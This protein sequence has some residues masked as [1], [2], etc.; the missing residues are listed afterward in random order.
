MDKD[1]LIGQGKFT[2][3]ASTTTAMPT[4]ASRYYAATSTCSLLACCLL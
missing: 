3:C 2:R 1:S 4:R